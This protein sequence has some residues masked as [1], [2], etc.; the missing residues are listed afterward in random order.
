MTAYDKLQRTVADFIADKI[1]DAVRKSS[2][3]QTA[4]I[5]ALERR[6]REV[7]GQRNAANSRARELREKLA[8]YQ[9]LIAAL[10]KNKQGN[11]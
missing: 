10:R 1:A 8:E 11:D 6:V 3:K 4:R 7:E 9:K 5:K 2:E